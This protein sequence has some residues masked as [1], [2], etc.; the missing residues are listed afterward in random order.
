VRHLVRARYCAYALGA[1]T[2]REFLLRTWHP[3]TVGS[4]RPGDLTNDNLQ[5]L[6]LEIVLADQKG[7]QGRAEFKA[8]YREGADGPLR[9]HHERALFHR[10]KG[11]WMY[12]E[13]QVREGAP[14]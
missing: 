1:G 13:G 7:E 6:G 4:V 11:L 3:A 2:H 12:L 5:W 9:V 8:T 14:A 10:M